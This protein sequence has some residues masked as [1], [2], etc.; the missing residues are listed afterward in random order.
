MILL[1][2]PIAWLQLSHQKIR[3]LA[4]LAGVTFVTV[5]LFMQLGFQG[6]LYRSAVRLHERLVGDIFLVSSQYTSITAQQSFSRLRL[7]QALSL[8]EV[9]SVNALYFQFAKLKNIE[10]GEKNSIFVF[11]VDPAKPTFRDLDSD[12][13]DLLKQPNSALFDQ[14]SRKEFGPVAKVFAQ[15]NR[16]DIEVSPY[17]DVTFARRLEIRG[18]FTQGPSFGVD[19]NL[20]INYTTFPDIFFERTADKIDV[21]AVTLKPGANVQTVIQTLQ[22]ELPDDVI[23]LSRDAFINKEKDY[24]G[25]RTPIGFTF[26]LMVTMGFVVGVVV[27]YQILYSNISNNLTE[28][29]TLKAIG[30]TNSYLFGFVF[31]QAVILAV[32]GFVPGLGLAFG[33]YDLA[34]N[35]TQLPVIMTLPQSVNVFVSIFSMCFI[36]GIFAVGKLRS[37]DPADIF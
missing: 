21:G 29:A 14:A 9:E 12:R 33:L 5:L 25:T 28:F 18:L 30:H 15:D 2:I 23:I 19:G 36:S 27:V 4:T 22:A 16:L 31:Q 1:H 24:W 8:D 34:R 11:G 13:L 32:F 37:A 10:T 17:N 35:A 7:Y 3:F 6:A 26:K 20:I